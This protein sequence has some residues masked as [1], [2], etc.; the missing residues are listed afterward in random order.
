MFTK[1]SLRNVVMVDE[2]LK[3]TIMCLFEGLTRR[4]PAFN[5]LQCVY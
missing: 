1:D 3:K 5:Y 2:G 4:M